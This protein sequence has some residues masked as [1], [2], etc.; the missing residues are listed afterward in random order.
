MTFWTSKRRRVAALVGGPLAVTAIAVA[1]GTSLVGKDHGAGVKD[2][3]DGRTVTSGEGVGLLFASHGDIDNIATELE[4]YIKTSFQKN[5]G[6]PLPGWSRNILTNPAYALS[7]RTVRAQYEQIGPTRYKSNSQIQANLI[8]SKL[9]SVLPGARVY[10]GYNFTDP[11]IE[12][13]M[14]QMRRDGVSKIVVMNKGAQ[15]SYASSGENLED[16][17]DYLSKNPGYDAEILGVLSY[18]DDPRF[19]EVLAKAIDADAKRLFP[20]VAPSDICILMGSHGLPT[21]LIG[22][23]DSAIVQMQRNI[24]DLRKALP[25]YPIYHGFLNDDFF[26]G[27]QW[28]TPKAIDLAPQLVTD[29]CRNVLMDGRLSFTTHHRATLYD[30]DVEVKDLIEKELPGS[31]VVLAPNFD[32]DENFASLVAS[33]T[34]ETLELKGQSVYLKK[35]GEQALAP[36]TVGAPGVVL[37]S[38]THLPPVSGWSPA[39]R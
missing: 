38:V 14:E 18:S 1:C 8:E 20:G 4:P 39:P 27:A 32:D 23:G 36:D 35:M 15:F 2:D 13:T 22:R 19:V 9:Q 28:V 5:V 34:K 21:W 30:L 10:L 25:Q 7:V 11:L 33:L 3:R 29:E 24:I 16:V 31:R 6:I 26:P 17:L 12:K 37:E